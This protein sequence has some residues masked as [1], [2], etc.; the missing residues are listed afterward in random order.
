MRLPAFIET[1]YD[2]GPMNLE[3]RG[4]RS[5][6]VTVL[7]CVA[8]PQPRM[9]MWVSDHPRRRLEVRVAGLGMGTLGIGGAT[10]SRYTGS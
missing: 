3:D 8:E 6:S 2:A 7:T 4:N 5:H 10:L 1:R 9:V